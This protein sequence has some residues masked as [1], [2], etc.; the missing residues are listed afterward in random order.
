MTTSA[1]LRDTQDD[2]AL[3]RAT[4]RR[5]SLRLIPFILLLYIFNFLDRT[6]VGIAALQMNRDLQFSPAAYSLGAGIF[7]IAYAVF[8]VPSNIFLAR[9]GPRFWIARICIT[10]GIIA[11]AMMFVRTPMHFYVLR[12]LLGVAE[13]GFFPGI[14]FYLSQ[15]FPATMRARA[16]SRFMLGIPLANT[17]G[18]FVGGWLLTL[19]G[20]LGIAGWQWL[21]V[22]EGIPSVLLGVS[23]LFVLTDKPAD[24]RWL[25]GQQREWL[26]ARMQRDEDTSR[27]PHGLPPL[28]ALRN[29]FLWLTAIAFMLVNTGA[30]AY[31]FWGPTIIRDTLGTSSVETGY[32][33]ALI[34]VVSAITMLLVSKSSDRMNERFLHAA[35]SVLLVC[36]GAA[37]V[38]LLPTPALRICALALMPMGMCSFL[39]P[40]FCLPGMLFRGSALA[41]AIALVNSIGNVGGF[42][43]P[44]VIGTLVSVTGSNDGAFLSLAALAFVGASIIVVLRRH[45]SVSA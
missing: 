34:G 3:G 20:R 1:P 7:F 43:G 44:N 9:V 8:E 30:Y 2:T 42:L 25:D 37:G 11:S 18:G 23:V 16:Q 4:M 14:V 28:R 32:V 6:N 36:V 26:V 39:S 31:Q 41:A 12:F 22:L 15:W 45:A 33:V 5:V 17:I 38:A 21:F 24:A 29:G 10:W 40:Y 27:A 13:A 35:G 19:D